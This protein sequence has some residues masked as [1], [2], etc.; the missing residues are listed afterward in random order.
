[1]K[2]HNIIRENGS[3]EVD[4]ANTVDDAEVVRNNIEARCRVIRGELMYNVLLG[5]PLK[6]SKEDIDLN[7]MN[8]IHNTDGVVDIQEF[9]SRMIGHKYSANI[10]VLTIYKPIEVVI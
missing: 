5:I 4:I 10:K 7:I 3:Y 9:E 8:I 6:G 1:M 2:G